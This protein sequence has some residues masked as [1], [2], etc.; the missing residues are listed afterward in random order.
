M[1]REQTLIPQNEEVISSSEKG[2]STSESHYNINNRLDEL[3]FNLDPWA[4]IQHSRDQNT[5]G[6]STTE[7]PSPRLQLFTIKTTEPTT[8]KSTTT[9]KPKSLDDLFIHKIGGD[10]K[11]LQSHKEEENTV[12]PAPESSTKKKSRDFA[13]IR[14]KFRPS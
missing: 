7:A 12:P 13:S 4:H 8:T 1:G 11:S 3:A 10:K 6:S 5:V 2:T 9:F 14:N